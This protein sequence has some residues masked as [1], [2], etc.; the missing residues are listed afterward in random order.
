MRVRVSAWT[1]INYTGNDAALYVNVYCGWLLVIW[2]NPLVW[3]SNPLKEAP[4]ESKA[5][6]GP[7]GIKKLNCLMPAMKQR[8]YGKEKAKQTL[9]KHPL[10]F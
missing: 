10:S 9:N 5:H 6:K 3:M 1:G 2:R 4:A 7:T 8:H